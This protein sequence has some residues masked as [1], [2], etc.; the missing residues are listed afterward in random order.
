MI[1]FSVCQNF[2]K[3]TIILTFLTIMLQIYVW[4]TSANYW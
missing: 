2:C 3:D 4:V 1:G